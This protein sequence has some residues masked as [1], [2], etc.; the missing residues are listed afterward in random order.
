M[1]E[2]HLNSEGVEY[3]PSD[4]EHPNPPAPN[5]AYS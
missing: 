3:E 4:E 5:Q 2:D 1:K